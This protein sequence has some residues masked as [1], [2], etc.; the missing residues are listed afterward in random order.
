MLDYSL[1]FGLFSFVWGGSVCPGAS[2]DYVPGG[3]VGKFHE[4]HDAHPL[5][6]QIHASSF[7]AT[8]WGEMVLFFSMQQDVRRHP[9]G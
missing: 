5:V 8:Q 2:L 9:M 4:M 6:Q 7:G 1:L 3:W